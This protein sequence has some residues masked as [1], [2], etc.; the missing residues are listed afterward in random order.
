MT[1]SCCHG[2]EHENRP[3][4]HG[5]NH[6]HSALH[7][8]VQARSCCNESLLQII[9]RIINNS[10]NNLFYISNNNFYI[11]SHVNHVN[12]I[13]L[14]SIA[15]CFTMICHR[16]CEIRSECV[17]MQINTVYK[18]SLIISH[19]TQQC[20]AINKPCIKKYHMQTYA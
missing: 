12:G 6:P 13:T 11:S 8:R 10:F 18:E 7:A 4:H 19:Y 5:V 15:L 14:R 17:Q 3:W 2:C 1:L 9:Q 16:S 20:K